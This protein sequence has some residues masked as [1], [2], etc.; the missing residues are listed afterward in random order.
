MILKNNRSVPLTFRVRGR[1]ITLQPGKTLNVSDEIGRLI[2]SMGVQFSD[3]AKSGG[4]PSPAPA[5]P[6]APE[7]AAPAAVSPAPKKR[8]GKRGASKDAPEPPPSDSGEGEDDGVDSDAPADIDLTM[9]DPPP[10]SPTGDAGASDPVYGDD[11][12]AE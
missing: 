3:P 8:G 1:V 10:D 11:D 2:V 4:A 9:D 12:D 6:V 7:P 5:E